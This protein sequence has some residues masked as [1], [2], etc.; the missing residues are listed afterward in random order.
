MKILDKLD[1]KNI[2][3]FELNHTKDKI[4][5][6][7]KCDLIYSTTLSKDEL[8]ELIKELKELHKEMV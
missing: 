1:K 8:K 5:V 2:V 4:D 7:E 3:A 6:Y